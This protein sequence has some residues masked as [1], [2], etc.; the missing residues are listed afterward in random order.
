[1]RYLGTVE[2]VLGEKR[3]VVRSDSLVPEVNDFV[4]GA[5]NNKIGLVRRIFGPVECPYIV[6]VSG[7]SVLADIVGKKVYCGGNFRNG[8]RKRRS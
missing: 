2:A 1:M 3:F 7:E 8:N 5:R 6:V 4:Y